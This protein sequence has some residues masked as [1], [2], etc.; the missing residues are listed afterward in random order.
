MVKKIIVVVVSIVMASTI[1]PFSGISTYDTR[2]VH[3]ESKNLLFER[4]YTSNIPLQNTGGYVYKIY[5]FGSLDNLSVNGKNYEFSS[6]NLR[7]L[8]YYRSNLRNWGISY[9]HYSN[10]AVCISGASFR[11]IL[12]P[13]FIFG[14]FFV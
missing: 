10:I 13:N 12:K 14:V 8:Q 11:G 1:L 7:E 3:S 9:G 5:F 4:N 2:E 6:H